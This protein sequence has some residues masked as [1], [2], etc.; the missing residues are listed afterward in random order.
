MATTADPARFIY[1]GNAM[2]LGGRIKGIG[3]T[4]APR[5]IPCPPTSALTVAGGLSRITGTGSS[6]EDIVAWG[7][8]VAESR[9][10]EVGDRHITTVTVSVADFAA[11]NEPHKFKAAMLKATIA[12][13]HPRRGQPSIAPSEILFAGL[14]LNG[15]EIRVEFDDDFRRDATF[16]AFEERYR[17]SE[18]F[19]RKYQNRCRRPGLR[20]GKFGERLPRI[21]G[22]VSTSIVKCIHY[23]GEHIDG[24]VLTFPGFGRIYLGELLMNENNKRLTMLRSVMKAGDGIASGGGGVDAEI[25]CAE[26]DPNGSWG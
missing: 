20:A 25:A 15:K 3:G 14:S 23:D 26:A 8:T 4:P 10:E 21:G 24:H 17:T 5:L 13:D 19:F 9:G 1:H 18:R 2:P 11:V 7:A 16:A 6:F 12:S 22:Y